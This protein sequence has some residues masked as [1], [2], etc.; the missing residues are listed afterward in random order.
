MQLRPE[1]RETA[2]TFGLRCKDMLN[3][4]LTKVKM[5]ENDATKR[6]VKVE[7]RNDTIL[8]T[9]L[10]D[11]TQFGDIGHRVRFRNPAN[12]EVALSHIL[13]EENFNYFTKLPNNVNKTDFKSLKQQTPLIQSLYSNNTK[14]ITGNN[15]YFASNV[16]LAPVPQCFRPQSSHRS[17]QRPQMQTVL[18]V[19]Q[20]RSL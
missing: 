2:Y 16:H 1:K 7:M 8:Q 4:L 19:S 18:P 12:I 5:S 13:E 20:P 10:R 15:P 11:I 14:S 17:L 3:L 9:Y 6:A